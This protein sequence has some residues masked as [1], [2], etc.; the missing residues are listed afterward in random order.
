MEYK[1]AKTEYRCDGCGKLLIGYEKNVF[2]DK[3]YI[4][5]KGKLTLQL[6]DDEWNRR[7]FV[8]LMP[9]EREMI[10]ICDL[11]CL[12]IYIKIQHSAYQKNRE[13]FLRSEASK[14]FEPHN[15]P[16]SKVRSYHEIRDGK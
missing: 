15:D 6:K 5:L 1:T 13:F 11:K 2:I 12:D 7:Y 8:H 14:G 16:R 3:D 10:T 9:R 4:C